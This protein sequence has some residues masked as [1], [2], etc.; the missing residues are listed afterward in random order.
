MRQFG[1]EVSIVPRAF[2]SQIHTSLSVCKGFELDEKPSTF[3]PP[4]YSTKPGP[5]ETLMH[6]TSSWHTILLEAQPRAPERV[7]MD[8][9][10]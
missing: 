6:R 9:I 1:T 2:A 7:V 8:L 4:G 5:K 10:L 3:H